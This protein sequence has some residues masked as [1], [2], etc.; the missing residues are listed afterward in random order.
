VNRRLLFAANWKMNK[1]PAQTRDYVLQFW[2]G[3]EA[4]VPRADIVLCAPFTDLETL[5][6][7]LAPSRVKYGAQDCYWEKAGA[8][9]GEISA[10]MLQ[11]IGATYCIVGHSERRRLFGETDETVARKT[12]ALLAVDLTP[13]VCVG[14]SL[15]EKQRGETAER[16]RAQIQAGLGQLTNEQRARLAI[17]YE[18]I[19]AIGSG[20]SEDPASAND[21]ATMIRT[22]ASGLDQA[23]ILYGGSMN[24]DNVADFCAQPEIDGGLVGGASLDARVFLTLVINGLKAAGLR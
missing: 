8:Y 3:A 5:R 1:G 18:P 13:I 12:A 14:E 17:A 21:V 2:G 10:A 22:A 24:A 4:L 11:D 23:R 7:E 19:W 15:E 6:V 20:L 9:T 16:V